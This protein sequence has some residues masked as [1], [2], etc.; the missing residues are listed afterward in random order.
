M[1]I[2]HCSVVGREQEK[3]EEGR[4]EKNLKPTR[5]EIQITTT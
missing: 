1:M 2:T 5:A 4:K 3:K